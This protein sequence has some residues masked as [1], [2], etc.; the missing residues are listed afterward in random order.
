MEIDIK[1]KI[2]DH[3][4]KKGEVLGEMFICIL[5]GNVKMHIDKFLV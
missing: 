5:L 2:E 1:I 3:D 4:F